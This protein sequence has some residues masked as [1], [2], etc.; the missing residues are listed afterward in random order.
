MVSV[1]LEEVLKILTLLNQK[2]G[3]S[4]TTLALCLASRWLLLGKKVVVVDADPQASAKYWKEI[5]NSESTLSGVDVYKAEH[6]T[7]VL[8]VKGLEG[9]DYVIIDTPGTDKLVTDKS[10]EVADAVII[11]VQPSAFDIHASLDTLALVN[12]HQVPVAYCVTRM[13]TRSYLGKDA[14]KAL[15][16]TGA[17]IVKHGMG[18]YTAYVRSIGNGEVPGT[19]F[20]GSPAA[21]NMESVGQAVEEVFGWGG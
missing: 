19:M 1:L 2:G 18:Q 20:P 12:D 15:T 13:I 9:Y 3:V 6:A 21:R 7:D 16:G 8:E 4:K 10:I 5:Q 14:E 11:P 17:K